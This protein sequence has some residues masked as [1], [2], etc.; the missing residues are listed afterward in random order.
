MIAIR[1]ENGSYIPVI[2][3]DHCGQIIVDA[4]GAME[5]SSSAPEGANAQAYYVHKGACEQAVSAKLG[6]MH[7]SD[8]LAVHLFDLLRSAMAKSDLERVKNAIDWSA[9]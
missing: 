5:L 1:K 9:G 2:L 7:G 6:G 3:C 4:M 8:E